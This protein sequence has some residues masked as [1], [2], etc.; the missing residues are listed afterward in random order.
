MVIYGDREADREESAS[1]SGLTGWGWFLTL[2]HHNCVLSD[3]LI[4]Q[5]SWGLHVVQMAVVP[6]AGTFWAYPIRFQRAAPGAVP[7]R[8][9]RQD[10]GCLRLC[11]G[12]EDN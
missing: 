8:P 11:H 12:P 2:S 6:V 10:N 9:V 1:S 3:S 7:K 4:A 5:N